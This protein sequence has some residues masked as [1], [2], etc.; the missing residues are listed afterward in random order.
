[1]PKIITFAHQKGGVGKSTLTLNVARGFSKHVKTVIV[2]LDPQ[3]ILNKLKPL[4]KGVEILPYMSDLN[5]LQNLD[6]EVVVI[7]TT[8]YLSEHLPHLSKVSHVTVVPT[9]ASPADITSMRDTI[10]L[11]DK[12]KSIVVFNMVK[13]N[14]TLTK[15]FKEIVKEQYGL[16]C[17]DTEVSDLVCFTRSLIKDLDNS[18]AINQIESLN[19]ELMNYL[20]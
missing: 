8:P 13:P 6:Y 12:S 17:A 2:D 18:K 3:G 5:E 19:K 14:T 11:I 9:K 20:N 4:I 7:D 16:K 1:M 15:D 10:P